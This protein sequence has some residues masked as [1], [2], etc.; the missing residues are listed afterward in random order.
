MRAKSRLID[1]L[2][3]SLS[4][5][6][7]PNLSFSLGSALWRRAAFSPIP[8]YSPML[9]VWCKFGHKTK[10]SYAKITDWQLLAASRTGL[11]TL[12][13]YS[14]HIALWVLS[15][16]T[17]DKLTTAQ[18]QRTICD[19]ETGLVWRFSPFL[20]LWW[21]FQCALSNTLLWGGKYNKLSAVTPNT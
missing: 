18:S 14:S 20:K 1:T 11:S 19:I 15:V 7:T 6:L 13:Y 21:S 10:N 3:A 12:P 2:L 8:S 16:C 9:P 5:Y 4:I 17:T